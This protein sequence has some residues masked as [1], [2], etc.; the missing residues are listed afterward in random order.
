[1]KTLRDYIDIIRTNEGIA[2]N[3]AKGA[4]AAVSHVA[5]AATRTAPA[6][7]G[8]LAGWASKPKIAS[9]ISKLSPALQ[10]EFLVRFPNDAA[11]ADAQDMI[12][13]MQKDL[14]RTGN[15]YGAQSLAKAHN[16]LS[17][18]AVSGPTDKLMLDFKAALKNQT[19]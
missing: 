9:E 17:M 15:T 8:N 16:C 12:Y 18:M 10:H 2:S 1:M 3:L 4:A 19:P 7:A 14:H 6:V 13:S 5:P 11:I